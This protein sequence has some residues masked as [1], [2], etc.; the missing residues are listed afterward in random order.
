[1]TVS[2]IATDTR[3]AVITSATMAPTFGVVDDPLLTRGTLNFGTYYVT[4]KR[5]AVVSPATPGVT[6][7]GCVTSPSTFVVLDKRVNPLVSFATVSNTSCDTN[8]DGQV[9]VTA[10]TASGPGSASNYNFVWTS[11]PDLAGAAYSA[12]NS[13][14]TNT[15]T[16]APC[17]PRALMA[18]K[19]A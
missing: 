5:T 10:T 11:D 17:A 6:G 9:T 15:A 3:R 16:S 7:S 19:A 8:Y 4:A 18:V 13:A 2:G 1:M 12:S 14:T